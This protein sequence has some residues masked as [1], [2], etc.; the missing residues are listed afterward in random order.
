MNLFYLQH[1]VFSMWCVYSGPVRGCAPLPINQELDLILALH[2][3]LPSARDGV[4]GE[5][6]R[7][8]CG[9]RVSDEGRLNQGEEQRCSLEQHFCAVASVMLT[10]HKKL[11]PS[12]T[13]HVMLLL[14]PV[15]EHLKH[16]K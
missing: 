13:I 6:G 9:R 14:C 3:S 10:H 4:G 7:A 12:H 1:V 8:Q 5:G 11:M 15:S 2:S 16:P